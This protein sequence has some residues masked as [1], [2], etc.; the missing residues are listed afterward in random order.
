MAS[1]VEFKNGIPLTSFDTVLRW[2][3]VTVSASDGS[4]SPGIWGIWSP[5]WSSRAT[6]EPGFGVEMGCGWDQRLAWA[7]PVTGSA[8]Q[9]G[10]P[11]LETRLSFPGWHL[12]KG[13]QML[14]TV[15]LCKEEGCAARLQGRNTLARAQTRAS[16]KCS[17]H[18][19]RWRARNSRDFVKVEVIS[20]VQVPAEIKLTEEKNIEGRYCV[21]WGGWLILP[22]LEPYNLTLFDFYLTFYYMKL[23]LHEWFIDCKG[24]I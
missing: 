2:F 17:L 6:W 16:Q 7:V 8:V 23:F 3:W 12:E 1:P 15:M 18:P 22:H 20:A 14:V 5:C 11:S 9:Q 10:E 13:G 21:V 24:F 4:F 19:C